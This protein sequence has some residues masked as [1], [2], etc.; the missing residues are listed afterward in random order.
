MGQ[1]SGGPKR[2]IDVLKT[3]TK[4]WTQYRLPKENDDTLEDEENTQ[5]GNDIIIEE[6]E[7]NDNPQPSPRKI[8]ME[9]LEPCERKYRS[10]SPLKHSPDNYPTPPRKIGNHFSFLSIKG[11]WYEI[12]HF[13][14]IF[15]LLNSHFENAI[16]SLWK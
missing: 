9:K 11:L 13:L 3:P 6:N 8:N 5:S 7:E 16:F 12:L 2:S 15:L 10:R 14:I 1:A 4:M